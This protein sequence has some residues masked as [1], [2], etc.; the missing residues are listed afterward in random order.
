MSE[1][2]KQVEYRRTIPPLT[3]GRI[4]RVSPITGIITSITVHFPRGC[5]QLVS[6]RFGIEREGKGQVF[7]SPSETYIA[8]D[9]W[10]KE[11]ALNEYVEQGDQIWVDVLNA[12]FLNAH[13]P[14][15]LI[16][17]VGGKR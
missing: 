10:T 16:E 11:F 7:P 17:I 8:L 4:T 15:V 1:E 13:T 12:D 9:D 6:L 2:I 14:V 5:N 3:G